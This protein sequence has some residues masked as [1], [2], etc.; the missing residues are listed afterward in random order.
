MD[1]VFSLRL[2]GA[3]LHNKVSFIPPASHHPHMVSTR[4]LSGLYSHE[5][6]IIPSDKSVANGEFRGWRLG[7]KRCGSDEY[8]HRNLSRTLL[9]CIS[10]GTSPRKIR[11][12]N[13]KFLNIVIIMIKASV[14]EHFRCVEITTLAF[15]TMFA[16]RA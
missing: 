1:N 16:W 3:G 14:F 15:V 9:N 6:S 2:C 13:S 10:R 12:E 8:Q 7:Y 11:F 4:L 5:E